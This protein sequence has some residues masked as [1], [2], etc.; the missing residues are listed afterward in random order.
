MNFIATK[1]NLY[2]NIKLLKIYY[3][4]KNYCQLHFI[5]YDQQ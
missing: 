2:L 5:I 1:N 3:I 4:K